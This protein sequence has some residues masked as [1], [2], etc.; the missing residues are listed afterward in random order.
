MPHKRSAMY[1]R[2]SASISA[3]MSGMTGSWHEAAGTSALLCNP[4]GDEAVLPLM[5]ETA[6][7][8]ICEASVTL[9]SAIASF[10]EGR[11][12]RPSTAEQIEAGL[13][14]CLRWRSC[15]RGCPTGG[16]VGCKPPPVEP[17]EVHG[18]APP[19]PNE[20]GGEAMPTSDIFAE[21]AMAPSGGSCALKRGDGCTAAGRNESK[22]PSSALRAL[23]AALF[24][25]GGTARG[26]CGG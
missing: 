21:G 23:S 11:C 22:T 2:R 26:V 9:S 13:P 7:E 15:C 1:R 10:D 20:H 16:G 3:R 12:G 25:C 24:C 5:P 14:I 17:N 18:D 6:T 4:H 8:S 19:L